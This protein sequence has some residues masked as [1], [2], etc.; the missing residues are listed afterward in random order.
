[1]NTVNPTPSA[2]PVSIVVNTVDRAGA[3]AALL[4]ALEHQSYAH[5]EVIVVVGPT[6]DHTLDV[7]AQYA[8]RVR[9]LR[10]NRANLSESR[11][12]GL[13]AAR[14]E[15][16]AFIDDDA[17][18]SYHWLAQ[19]IAVFAEARACGQDIAVVGG[20]VYLVHPAQ[21]LIQHWLGMISNLGEQQDVRLPGA[22]EIGGMGV[23]WT[24]RPMGTNM[25]FDR[26]T[27]LAVGGFDPYFEWV[28]DEADV[29]MRLALAGHGVR[30]LTEAPVYHVPGSSRNR[31]ARTYTGRWWIVTKASVYFAVR[32]GRA[33]G[34]PWRDIGLRVLHIV[35]G[36]WIGNWQLFHY[37]HITRR[38]MWA[39]RLRAVAAGMQGAGQ[40]LGA[41]RLLFAGA[42][43]LP[44]GAPAGDILLFQTAGS[45]NAPAVDP[46]S[47]SMGEPPVEEPPLRIGI[48][49]EAFLSPAGRT[50]TAGE[51]VAVTEALFALGHAVHVL[52]A[53]ERRTIIFQSGAFVHAEL[54]PHGRDPLA[55]GVRRLVD[56]DG[57][58]LLAGLPEDLQ[59]ALPSVA[60]APA[61]AV[62]VEAAAHTA[63]QTVG[64]VAGQVAGQAGPDQ[65]VEAAVPTA[66]PTAPLSPQLRAALAPL[67]AAG[68]QVRA[69]QP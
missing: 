64:Q 61:G 11:N 69:V 30:S 46:I 58:Q 40:G 63:R 29:T 44:D 16:V 51:L 66:V 26:R 37:G 32:N 28:F 7:L 49:G 6:R 68:Y 65:M 57:I 1:M 25:A 4:A 38:E 34:Q 42:S 23:F 53:A 21:P 62:A 67:L 50:P 41:R 20:S 13:R 59:A 10:C 55:A 45:A 9:V 18:P 56:N 39:R 36:A 22:D 5:F 52:T 43:N 31:V 19:L 27:L 8:G 12:L 54:L 3:L 24:E 60:A 2:I 35:H 15:I 33:A 47:G 14:G 17:V 48:I